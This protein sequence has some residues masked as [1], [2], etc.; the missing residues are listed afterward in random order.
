MKL[1]KRFEPLDVSRP[2]PTGLTWYVLSV[3]SRREYQCAR[4]LEERGWFTCV[5]VKTIWHLAKK[6]RGGKAEPREKLVLPELGG[7]VFAGHQGPPNWLTLERSF[8]IHGPLHVNHVPMPLPEAQIER[9]RLE[10][11]Q[12]AKREQTRSSLKSGGRATVI[13]GAYSGKELDVTKIRGPW[14]EVIIDL[15][16]QSIQAKISA[17]HLE[18][19]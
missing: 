15:F 13:A 8:H 16:G 4:W 7:F 3:V 10:A 11:I 9:F 5:P 19:A 12:T 14:A 1:Q 2:F 17:E 18:A 6:G